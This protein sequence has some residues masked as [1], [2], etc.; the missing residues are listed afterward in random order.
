MRT[1][2]MS[3][4]LAF[5]SL[6]PARALAQQDDDVGS[7]DG[8]L[9]GSVQIAPEPRSRSAVPPPS[10]TG[11]ASAPGQ[12]HTV[13]R[14]DTLWDLSQKFLGSPWYWP[15]VWSYNPE[16]ANPHWIYPGNAVRF[17]AGGEEVPTEVEAGEQSSVD[18]GS[19]VDDGVTVYGKIGIQGKVGVNVATPGFVTNREVE[20]S[21]KIFGSFAESIELSNADHIY[22]HF[23]KKAPRLGDVYLVYRAAGEILHPTT[24]AP[25][26]TLT[27]L[28]AEVKVTRIEKDNRTATVQIWKQYDE[29]LR[30]DLVGPMGD[31]IIRQVVGKP[32]DRDV[33]DATVVADV[34]KYPAQIGEHQL[35][36]MDKGS[37]DGVKSGS[38][39][40]IYRQHDPFPQESLLSPS[41]LEEGVPREDIGQCI[42][43]EVKSKVSICLMSRSI[44]DIFRGDHAEIRA[45]NSR[46]ASR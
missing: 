46:R 33:K 41:V 9:E 5:V 19:M 21:G 12:Q 14:G 16:I 39:F 13:E 36:I 31:P 22:V 42:A 27:I 28:L 34:R 11:R 32:S 44:R 3:A 15:K 24:Q 37:D 35:V 1:L 38:V 7:D 2:L 6:A 4:A 45:S 29:V 43:F 23:E 10:T 25:L 40:S 8:A 18:E 30:G 17:Y 20:E 26:G